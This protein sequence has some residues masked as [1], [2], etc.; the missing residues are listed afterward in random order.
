MNWMM[1]VMCSVTRGSIS[2][3]STSM[4]AMSACRASIM[5]DA[6]SCGVVFSSVARRMILSSISV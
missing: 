6:S 4:E 2:A 3:G 5:R 1:S